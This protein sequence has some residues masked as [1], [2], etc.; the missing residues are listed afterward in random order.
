MSAHSPGPW[1]VGHGRVRST[2]GNKHITRIANVHEE[3]IDHETRLANAALIVMAPEML[4]S[5]ED[6]VAIVKECRP[7]TREME[8]RLRAAEEIISKAKGNRS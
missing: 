5:L 8:T 4:A 7:I 2:V 1:R 3:A 6:L